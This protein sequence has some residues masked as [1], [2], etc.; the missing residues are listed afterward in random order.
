MSSGLIAVDLREL[1][2]AKAICSS[3]KATASLSVWRF[4]LRLMPL[5]LLLK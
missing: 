4:I 1:Q 3:V 5:F 2:I